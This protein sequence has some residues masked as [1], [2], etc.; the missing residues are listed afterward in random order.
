M[1][2]ESELRRRE[3]NEKDWVKERERERESERDGVI[4]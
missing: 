3:N 4:D 1:R 2:M